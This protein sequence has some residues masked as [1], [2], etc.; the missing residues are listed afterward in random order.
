MNKKIILLSGD[1]NSI[2]SEIIYKCWKKIP[3]NKRANIFIISNYNLLKDQFKKLKYKINPI[4]VK[5]IYE[6]ENSKEMKIININLK[7]KNPFNVPKELSAKYVIESL[8]L[9]HKIALNKDVAGLINCPINKNIFQEKR[10]GVTEYLASKC[11]IKNNSEAMLIS[12]EKLMVSPITTH[13]DLKSIPKKINKTLIVNKVKTIN[14]WFK[15]SFGK[16]PKIAILGLNPHNGELREKSEEKL[17]IIPA[18]NKLKKLGISLFGP[19]AADTIFIEDYKRYDVIVGMY[20]DQVLAPFKTIFKFD[21]IN[22]T[23]G[24]N[25]LRISPDHGVATNKILKKKSNPLSLF[26]CF[27]F[28]FKS[29]K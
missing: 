18:I 24:L 28:I 17:L 25:Y 5:N 4:V 7:Y 10:I 16:K 22:I 29:T 21:A 26:K 19:F 12:N 11:S 2:N 27:D 14:K 6:F 15:G 20:H 9:A 13:V 3:I 23:L 1:P 8:N